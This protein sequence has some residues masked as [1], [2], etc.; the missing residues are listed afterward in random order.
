MTGRCTCGNAATCHSDQAVDEHYLD[1]VMLTQRLHTNL[2]GEIDTQLASS[3]TTQLFTM[4]LERSIFAIDSEG[5][6]R[7]L[8]VS[9]IIFA[10]VNDV[11]RCEQGSRLCIVLLLPA[12][13][14]GSRIIFTCR[15][16]FLHINN[17]RGSGI[18][19]LSLSCTSCLAG[20]QDGLLT[21]VVGSSLGTKRLD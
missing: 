17:F 3:S 16:S 12:R 15:Q 11:E 6:V 7:I 8:S 10:N 5:Q 4:A 18:A 21:L 9:K 14:H 1:Q 20:L 19:V 2:L 13:D